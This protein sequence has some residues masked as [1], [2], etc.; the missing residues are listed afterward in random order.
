MAQVGKPSTQR[1][2]D[3][4]KIRHTRKGEFTVRLL[5]DVCAGDDFFEAEIIAG[6]AHLRDGRTSGAPGEV[7]GMRRA[8]VEF[9]ERVE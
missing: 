3:V 4:W 7:I 2:G 1:K 5:T 6:Y 9:L 8:F